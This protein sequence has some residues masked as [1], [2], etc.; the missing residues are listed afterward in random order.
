MSLTI[1]DAIED[2][3]EE[4]KDRERC[5]KRLEEFQSISERGLT[6]AEYHDLCDT[7]LRASDS[8]G[9][10]LLTVFPFLEYDKRGANY[11]FFNLPNQD[12][13]KIYVRIPN[14][15]RKGVEIIVSHYCTERDIEL[16]NNHYNLDES[17]VKAEINR[18]ERFLSDDTPVYE[19]AGIIFP[20]LVEWYATIKYV[21][22]NRKRYRKQVEEKLEKACQ[23]RD[24]IVSKRDKEI[25]EIKASRESQQELLEKYARLFLKWCD[26]V[27]VQ[28]MSTQSYMYESEV[29]YE[30]V[31]GK[32][33][34]RE[35][36]SSI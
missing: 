22:G 1:Q 7:G 12:N 27:R 18:G 17:I 15:R 5:L 8:L 23:R 32:V 9:E 11:F 30:M 6:E 31:N 29:I 4:I 28:S 3:Q 20:T 36:I 21:F 13:S 14:S 25:E 10:A 26:E 33:T 2:V 16:L 34:S 35:R 19:K 24:S